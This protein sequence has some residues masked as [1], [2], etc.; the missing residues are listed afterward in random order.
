[1]SDWTEIAE[2]R[3]EDYRT[4][5]EGVAALVWSWRKEADD[6]ERARDSEH[7]D[8]VTVPTLRECADALADSLPAAL[9]AAA[10]RASL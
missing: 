8:L 10:G 5:L 9:V 3:A 2:Q 1:M 7:M 6:I 4:Y